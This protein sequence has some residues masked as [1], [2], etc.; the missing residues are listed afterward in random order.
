MGLYKLHRFESLDLTDLRQGGMATGL[1]GVRR[2]QEGNSVLTDCEVSGP[3][4]W[5]S[6]SGETF[7]CVSSCFLHSCTAGPQGQTGP[8]CGCGLPGGSKACRPTGGRTPAGTRVPERSPLGTEAVTQRAPSR[9]QCSGRGVDIAA[10]Y[11]YFHSIEYK[12]VYSCVHPD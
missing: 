7:L 5:P 1:P 3:S 8:H 9:R 2:L 6:T 11:S 10:K 4:A 12:N